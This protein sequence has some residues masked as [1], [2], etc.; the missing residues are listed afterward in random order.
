MA[1]IS[2]RKNTVPEPGNP[3]SNGGSLFSLN[4]FTSKEV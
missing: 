2:N 4:A 1:S 3:N